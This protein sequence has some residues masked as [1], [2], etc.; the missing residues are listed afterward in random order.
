MNLSPLVAAA[1]SHHLAS[2]HELQTIYSYAD[3]L[4]MAEVIRVK[5]YNEWWAM[6]D[7]KRGR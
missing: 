3:L 5:N 4:D 6:E 1:V 7:A 2:L